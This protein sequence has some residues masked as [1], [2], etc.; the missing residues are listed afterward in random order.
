[1]LLSAA[2]LS[3]CG[4]TG[5]LDAVSHMEASGT[6]YKACLAEHKRDPSACDAARVTYQADLADAQKMR[7]VLTDW[8][9]L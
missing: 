5:K 2:C 3:A 4:I 1:V 8:R 6:S 7:G 9:W